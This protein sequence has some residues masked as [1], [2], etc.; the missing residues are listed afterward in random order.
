MFLERLTENHYVIQVRQTPLSE[1]PFNTTSIN[2]WN[3]APA[4]HNRN[5]IVLN[6]KEP[7]WQMKLVFSLSGG[8]L[9]VYRPQIKRAKPLAP[10][11][12]VHASIGPRQR[13]SI[14]FGNGIQLPIVHTA[15]CRSILLLHYYNV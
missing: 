13:I 12:G 15:T 14:L 4:L 6:W 10:V 8:H 9:V 2:L 11:H 7:L 1:I 3:V 5:G